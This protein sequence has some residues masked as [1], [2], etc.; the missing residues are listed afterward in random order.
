MIITEYDPI[1]LPGA[2]ARER[3]PI[4]IVQRDH[5]AWPDATFTILLDW[6][7]SG[8]FWTWSVDIDGHGRIIEQ[9]PAEYGRQ[10]SYREYVMF[11]FVDLSATVD[12]VTPQTLG[13]S[14]DLVAFP[15]LRS[16]GFG[17]WLDRQRVDEDEQQTLLEEWRNNVNQ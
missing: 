17:E 10:Y 4:H 9:Q 2:T 8:E 13:S 5:P 16:P 15:G 14:V 1:D 11:L 12:S 6:N 7:N 3:E